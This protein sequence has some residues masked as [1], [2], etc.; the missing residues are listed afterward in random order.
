MMKSM[1]NIKPA[2]DHRDRDIANL[3]VFYD[4]SCP[5]CAREMGYYQ[6]I[7]PSEQIQWVNVSSCK[8]SVL[9]SGLT[10][11]AALARFHVELAEGRV[12]DGDPEVEAARVNSTSPSSRLGTRVGVYRISQCAPETTTALFRL[13]LPQVDAMRME[14]VAPKWTFVG[15]PSALLSWCRYFSCQKRFLPHQSVP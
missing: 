12:V 2:L 15:I 4:G 1:A 14:V 7:A 8:E 6:K 9:P 10:R 3:K 11:E 5:I 13:P